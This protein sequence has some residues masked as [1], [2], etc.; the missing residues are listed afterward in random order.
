MAAG[1]RKLTFGY[2][3]LRS[4]KKEIGRRRKGMAAARGLSLQA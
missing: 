4:S 3:G 2:F 1:Q